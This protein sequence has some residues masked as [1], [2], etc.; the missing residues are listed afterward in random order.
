MLCFCSR[1]CCS[2]AAAAGRG[3]GSRSFHRV[4]MGVWSWRHSGRCCKAAIACSR[5][6]LITVVDECLLVFATYDHSFWWQLYCQIYLIWFDYCSV[7][8][9]VVI[10]RP[11]FLVHPASKT[12]WTTRIRQLLLSS[13]ASCTLSHSVPVFLR[14][15][16]MTPDEGL[17]D[18]GQGDKWESLSDF[19]ICH[20]VLWGNAHDALLPSMVCCNNKLFLWNSF[21]G[22]QGEQKKSLILCHCCQSGWSSSFTL[23]HRSFIVS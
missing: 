4:C 5:G 20:L 14:S 9:L 8:C 22:C 16:L 21:S 6:R 23:N 19:L 7:L 12:H 2:W 10:Q 17:A 15:L 18:E 11:W 3:D 1:V 13:A